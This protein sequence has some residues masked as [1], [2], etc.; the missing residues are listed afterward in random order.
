MPAA[1][2]ALL[3][4]SD[5]TGLEDFARGLA[6]LGVEILSRAGRHSGSARPASRSRKSRNTPDSPRSWPDG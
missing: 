6:G 2:R 4:V 5:K 3:S 1:K